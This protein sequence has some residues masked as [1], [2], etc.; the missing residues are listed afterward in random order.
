MKIS[1]LALIALLSSVFYVS[2]SDENTELEK[3][4]ESLGSYEKGLLVL[5]EGRFNYDN[6]SV[7]FISNDFSLVQND[8][9]SIVNPKIKLGDVAQSIGF[10]NDYAFIVLNNSHKIEVVNRYTFSQITS[11]G[12]GL[13][14]PR[15]IVFAK[16]KA[17]VTNW[18]DVENPDDDYI[19]VINLKNYTVETKIP[20]ID[21]PE[22]ILENNNKLYVAHKGRKSYGNSISVI[23]ILDN[24][25]ITKINVG[26]VPAAMEKVSESLYVL[27]S[28]KYGESAGSLVKIN[29]STNQVDSS[30]TFGEKVNPSLMDIEGN[31]IYYTIGNEI[32]KTNLTSTTLPSSSFINTANQNLTSLYG[33]A[34]KNNSLFVGDAIDYA[35]NGKVFIYSKDGKLVKEFTSGINPN[36]FYFN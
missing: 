32:F 18:G 4:E 31:T 33:F 26:Y 11:I 3:K 30:L 8:V 13:S 24:K 25:L 23:N 6:S 17:Y 22:T 1:K 14:N 27:C 20:V 7:S 2:C 9:F 29:L 19:A 35:S 34:V 21:G 15:Y 10:Y 28:G 36:G 16:D 12:F 5:N